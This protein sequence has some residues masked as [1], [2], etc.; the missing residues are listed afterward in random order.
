MT[1]LGL[2]AG[3][4]LRNAVLGAGEVAQ[5]FL[6]SQRTRSVSC[7]PVGVSQ[8]LTVAHPCDPVPFPDLHR[9]LHTCGVYTHTHNWK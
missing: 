3:C 6:F 7:T 8:L 5:H 9:Y 4:F 2:A 1:V